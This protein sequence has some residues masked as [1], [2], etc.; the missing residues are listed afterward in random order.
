[1]PDR[2]ET[3]IPGREPIELVSFYEAFRDYYAQCELETKRWFVDHVRPD[4]WIFD[5][6]ANIGYYSILFAQL[7]PHG[8]VFAFE[9]TATA[10]MLRTN[11]RHHDVQNAEVHEVALGA[12]TG[13]R[14]DR[15]YRLW[16]TEGE[17]RTYP[18]YKL[19]DFID[20]HRIER[21]DCIKIDVDS[22][23]FE[24]LRGAEQTLLKKNPVIVV[25]LNDA[26]AK[27]NQSAGE[28]LAWLARRGYRRAVVLD[29]DNFML[30]R[31]AEVVPAPDGTASLELVFQRP[32]RIDEKMT[33]TAGTVVGPAFVK[34]AQLHNG[35]VARPPGAET[36]GSIPA[37]LARGIR[38]LWHAASPAPAAFHDMVDVPIET[39]ALRWSYALALQL[40]VPEPNGTLT[41]EV[42]VEVIAGKLGIAVCGED[43]SR[44]CAPER[45]L[46]AMAEPQR[47]VIKAQS[48]DVDSLIFR[49]VAWD[50]TR[51]LFKIVS[52]EARKA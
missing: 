43:I 12:I 48:R 39:T 4:W 44:F 18:F 8:R 10:A 25:E 34:A 31:G 6:G 1:M 28:A 15:I 16:G 17:V 33:A 41:M 46:A 2:V 5:V 35:A 9:P 27:R 36:N 20:Q 37:R 32:L 14:Q 11:L 42:G 19:D 50:G 13:E 24:V 23:D 45:T 38:S 22:F 52:L 26:L 7:A 49:N 29:H 40:D 47:V 21:V 51:T 3:A 30:Q